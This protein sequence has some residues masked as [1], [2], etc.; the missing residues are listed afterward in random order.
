MVPVE[1]LRPHIKT[2]KT[3]EVAEMQLAAGITKFKCAT[4]AEAELLGLVK[5]PD[6]LMAY[7]PL[8]AKAERFIQ[9]IKAYPETSFSCLVDN[10]VTAEMLSSLAVANR[11]S[12]SLYIDLNVGMNRTGIVPEQAFELYEKCN[13]LPGIEMLG[14]HAYDGHI[15]HPGQEERRAMCESAFVPVR[16]LSDRLTALGN[17]VNLIFGGSPSFPFHAAREGVECSPGTFVFWDKGYAEE[18]AEQDFLPAALVLCRVISLPTPSRICIDL[19][20]KSIAAENPLNR[21]VYFVNAPQLQPAGHSEEHMVIE[22]GEGHSWK[23]GDIL[24]AMPIH[25]CPTVALYESAV[26]VTRHEASGNWDIVA[27][28]RKINY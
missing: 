18:C 22:A 1:R 2:H 19:G 12:F 28:N 5:A 16:Q 7:Q 8:K 25:V 4:I 14:L 3:R 26:T 23:I 9:L 13:L 10:D 11:I 15:H 6:V 27:R 17:K 21:R 20:Y 24:Y